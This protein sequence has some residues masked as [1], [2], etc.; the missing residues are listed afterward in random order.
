[1][2]TFVVT[3]GVSWMVRVEAG[4]GQLRQAR[5]SHLAGRGFG[6]VS[7]WLS[8]L[9]W[10]ALSKRAPS[11]WSHKRFRDRAG[12]TA[13]ACHRDADASFC[14]LGLESARREHQPTYSH[15]RMQRK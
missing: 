9:T 4:S 5:R 10:R 12:M 15:S 6:P 7:K 2:G 11:D 13:F 1:M 8:C 3:M 14:A